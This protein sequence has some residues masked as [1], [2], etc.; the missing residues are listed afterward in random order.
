MRCFLMHHARTAVL[1]GTAYKL[2]STTCKPLLTT[3][4]RKSCSSLNRTLYYRV[5]RPDFTFCILSLGVANGEPAQLFD[6]MQLGSTA[7]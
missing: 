1:I 5:L 7:N 2:P 4:D 6:C 3:C